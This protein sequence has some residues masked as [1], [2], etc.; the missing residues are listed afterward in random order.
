M[1]DNS[2]PMP[3]HV[4]EIHLQDYLQVLFRRR[5]TLVL[6]FIF[7]FSAVT[8]YTF[9]VTPIYEAKAT[10]HVRENK[11][12]GGDLLGDLGL[13]QENPIETEIEIIKSR[14][15]LERVV[16]RLHLNWVVSKNK[17][18]LDFSILEFTST[19]EEPVYTVLLTG[20]DTFN[21]LD[22]NGRLISE[23]R[24][25]SL[26]S[27]PGF[28][29]VLKGL[30]GK[31][32]DQFE[33]ILADFSQT[34]HNVRSQISAHEVG[35]KTNIIQV[36]YQQT[37]PQQVRDVVQ[38]LSQVY[39]E[40]SIS[41][42][43]EEASK[44]VEFIEQQLD[45]VR[46]F[47]NS[48]EQSLEDY[49][50]KTGIIQLDSSA[51]LLV[52]RLSDFEKELNAL[53][54]QYRQIEFAV[55]GIKEALKRGETY[56][57]TVMAGD[58]VVSSVSQ[59]MA[60]LEVEKRGLLVE[61]TTD[62]PLIQRIQKQIDELQ[63]QLLT[64]FTTAQ[65]TLVV[66][67]NA[68]QKQ[69]RQG[70][71]KLQTLPKAELELAR[72]SRLA[73]VNSS[74]YIFLLE[75]HQETRIAKAA[76][77][78]NITII[79][80]AIIPDLPIKPQKKKNLLLG[81]IVGLML[82]VGLA[83]FQEYLDDTIKDSDSAK[84]L[85]GLPILSTIPFIAPQKNKK[86]SV[87]EEERRTLISHTD[88]RSPASEAFRSLRT[89]IHFSGG[90]AKSKIVL[91]TSTFPGEG[92]TTVAA[93]LALTMAQT[94]KKVLLIGCDLRKPTLHTVFEV[95]RV[96][97][98]TELLI[99][100]C[101]INATVHHT[102]FF[103]LDFINAGTIPP[104]PAELLGSKE[105]A[106]LIEKMQEEYDTL[107]LDA[108]PVLAV[109]DAPILAALA[110]KVLVLVEVGGVQVKAAQR[111]VEILRSVGA[112]IAGLILNDKT[113]KGA[114]YYSYYSYYGKRYSNDYV[115]GSE[116]VESKRPAGRGVI[117]RL[118]GRKRK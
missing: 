59:K 8:F 88:P 34:V 81:L 106:G 45:E 41:L 118:F 32:G 64:H 66:Q 57:P 15:N 23:G 72:L 3:P 14:T 1:H 10:L 73:K 115:Y 2:S 6:A 63:L 78:S 5:W 20:S 56:M 109:T 96:P 27:K 93:N 49:K 91:I 38:A 60:E 92:K 55:Q 101:E 114:D 90:K 42:K 44:A 33:L 39:L 26:V 50:Y 24:S 29:L 65:K 37:D 36:S 16:D 79:D 47:L 117:R 104:N 7:V 87:G 107:L 97:G 4:E 112:P 67:I 85:L 98:L 48:A 51:Q 103:H 99:G 77:I 116:S 111:A 13:S 76:T 84:R 100:D 71:K 75:K 11:V 82:G 68:L 12:K 94:G 9:W 83:F 35:R 110:D 22:R 19:A 105:M 40:R 62:H 52:E 18:H 28:S 25:G 89:S 58:P 95:P 31:A 70:E 69:L 43:S 46:G 61:V 74:M 86:D 80:P 102:G 53:D 21:V 108:P 17:S 30:N 113:A 54:L